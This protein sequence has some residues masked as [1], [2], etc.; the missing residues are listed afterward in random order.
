MPKG[1]CSCALYEHYFSFF[2]TRFVDV[3]HHWEE[4]TVIRN[5]EMKYLSTYVLK[6]LARK[7]SDLE[8]FY[9]ES[10]WQWKKNNHNDIITINNHSS[11]HI[12]STSEIAHMCIRIIDNFS[13]HRQS[14]CE[15]KESFAVFDFEH[16]QVF[17][18]KV[19]HTTFGHLFQHS[20]K[21]WVL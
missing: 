15:T 10:Q 6:L 17:S 16:E 14:S 1:I 21:D 12:T 4:E 8:Q 3:R 11:R 18:G 5:S 13:F 2:G 20:D 19:G 7:L 9:K